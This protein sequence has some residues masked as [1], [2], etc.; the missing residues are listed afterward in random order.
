MTGHF[1]TR[2]DTPERVDGLTGE[3]CIQLFD[4]ECWKMEVR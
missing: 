4:S 1:Q 2:V 3:Q